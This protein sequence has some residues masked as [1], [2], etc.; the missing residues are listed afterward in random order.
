MMF[1]DLEKTYDKVHPEVLGR[2]LEVVTHHI[3]VRMK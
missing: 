1:I 2:C 3:E